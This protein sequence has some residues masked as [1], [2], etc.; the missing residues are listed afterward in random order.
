MVLTGNWSS[1]DHEI[2]EVP[3][4]A[5]VVPPQT[6]ELKEK[7]KQKNDDKDEIEYLQKVLHLLWLVVTFEDHCG[8]TDQNNENDGHIEGFVFDQSIEEQLEIELQTERK[9]YLL[10][11]F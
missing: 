6:K 10:L 5:E 3:E 9:Q 2:E 11:F 4:V 1:N 7:F 8:S